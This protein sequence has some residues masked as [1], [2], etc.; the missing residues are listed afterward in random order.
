MRIL[1]GIILS[2]LAIAVLAANADDE[3]TKV[4]KTGTG[5]DYVCEQI[6]SLPVACSE[7][8]TVEGR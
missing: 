2:A 1:S 4:L 5:G 6:A 3:T 7:A 8:R